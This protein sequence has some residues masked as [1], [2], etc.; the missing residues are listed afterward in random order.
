M[1]N[2]RCNDPDYVLN[3]IYREVIPI[4]DDEARRRN[5][6]LVKEN[7]C[8]ELIND[9]KELSPLFRELFTK[10]DY[11]GSYWD[12]T[13]VSEATEFDINVVLKLPFDEACFM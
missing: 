4:S 7:V 11:T 3:T 13:R 12:G 9:M 5:V 2:M 8:S 1:S 10:V 6:Q